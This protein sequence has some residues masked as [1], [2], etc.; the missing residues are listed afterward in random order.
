MHVGAA[1]LDLAGRTARRA[2]AVERADHVALGD[3][4]AARV[5]PCGPHHHGQATHEVAQD[6]EGLALGAHHH[7][8]AGVHELRRGTLED[9]G[10]LGAAAQVV[11]FLGTGAVKPAEVDDAAHPRSTRG[12]GER[13]GAAPVKVAEVAAVARPMACTR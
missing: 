8:G 12:L 11:G 13:S 2:E 3:R 9:L 10:H 5:Y 4:L 1:E 7:R 6:H